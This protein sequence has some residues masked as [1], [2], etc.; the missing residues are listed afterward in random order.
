[1]THVKWIFPCAYE[2]LYWWY[3]INFNH[4]RFCMFSRRFYYS[5]NNTII[6]FRKKTS[7]IQPHYFRNALLERV[8]GK[9]SKPCRWIL[10]FGSDADIVIITNFI[11]S[12]VLYQ[13]LPV[14]NAACKSL[15]F[16]IPFSNSTRTAGRK[17]QLDSIDLLGIVL[18]YLKRKENMYDMCLIFG[19][20]SSTLSVWLVYAIKVLQKGTWIR[21]S[22]KC[23]TRLL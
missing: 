21:T 15:N 5:I 16:G 8:T 17:P 6:A 7:R 4:N 19:I 13:F 12:T 1:M 2:S 10:S 9:N 23:D 14:F 22:V 18:W 11:K 3:C 20:A